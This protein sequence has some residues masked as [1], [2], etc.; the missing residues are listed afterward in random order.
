MEL[1]SI[2]LIVVLII[3]CLIIVSVFQKSHQQKEIKRAGNKGEAI[4]NNML[5]SILNNED[6]FIKQCLFKY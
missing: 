5:K 3:A 2:G 6:V 1:L 4:F